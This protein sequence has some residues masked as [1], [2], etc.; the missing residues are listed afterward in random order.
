MCQKDIGQFLP[1]YK[2]NQLSNYLALSNMY[3]EIKLDSRV[4]CDQG[5]HLSSS[6]ESWVMFSEVKLTIINQKASKSSSE[7]V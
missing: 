7:T 3:T 4:L 2:N 5:L 6:H 1:N